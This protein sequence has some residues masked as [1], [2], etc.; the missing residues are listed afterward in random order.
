MNIPWVNA[1]LVRVKYIHFAIYDPGHK[2]RR[3][4][5]YSAS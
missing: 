1:F 3:E 2:V 4:T 5:V